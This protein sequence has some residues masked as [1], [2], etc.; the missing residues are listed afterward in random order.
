LS[1]GRHARARTSAERVAAP[2]IAACF[3]RRTVTS[4]MRSP[5]ASVIDCDG[6]RDAGV[7]TR[8]PG[9]RAQFARIA[10]LVISDCCVRLLEGYSTVATTSVKSSQL[11]SQATCTASVF[12]LRSDVQWLRAANNSSSTARGVAAITHGVKTANGWVSTPYA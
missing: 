3:H 1:C 2:A 5:S 8:R 4:P 10:D 7:Q 12:G 9:S 6:P 11:A